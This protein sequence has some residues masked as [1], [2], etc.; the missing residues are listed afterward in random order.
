MEEEALLIKMS[1]EITDEK[2]IADR[3]YYSGRLNT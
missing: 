2:I 3:T 1:M